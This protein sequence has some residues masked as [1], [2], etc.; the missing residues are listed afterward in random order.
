MNKILLALPFLVLCNAGV[1]TQTTKKEVTLHGEVV[2]IANYVRFGTK[3]DDPDRIAIAETSMKTGNPLGILERS[4]GKI[5][6]VTSSQANTRANE[7][8]R[9]FFGQRVFAKGVMYHR[10]GVSLFI[11]NDIGKSVK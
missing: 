8:L 4:T 1:H 5:Y 10:G 3:P 9:Q 6:L 7:K 2:D 11:M